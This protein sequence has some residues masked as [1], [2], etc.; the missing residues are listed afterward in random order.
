MPYIWLSEISDLITEIVEEN[1]SEREVE[2]DIETLSK[3]LLKPG[4]K[5]PKNGR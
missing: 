3:N 1:N 5:L 4:I 2:I